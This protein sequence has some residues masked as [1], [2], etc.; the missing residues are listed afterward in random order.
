MPSNAKMS[1]LTRL[2]IRF[3][4]VALAIGM[5]P[6]KAAAQE[7]VPRNPILIISSYNPDSHGI[8]STISAFENKFREL[9][10]QVAV[11]TENM[12]CKSLT[13][14]FDW[15]DNLGVILAKYVE[16]QRPSVIILLGQEAWSAYLSQGERLDTSIPVLC[17]MISSNAVLL[18][19]KG[20][21]ALDEWEPESIEAFTD[22]NRIKQIGGYAYRYD[23]AKNVELILDFFPQTQYVAFISDNTYGGVAMQA[24][25]KKE[26]AR[27]PSLNLILL[28]GRKHTTYSISEHI[29]QLPDNTAILIGTWRTDRNDSYFVNGVYTLMGAGRNIPAFTLA[30]TGM[31]YWAIAGYVPKYYNTGSDLA[32]QAYKLISAGQGEHPLELVQLAN[33]YHFDA[34]KLKEFGFQRKKLPADSIIEHAEPSFWSQYK[35]ELSIVIA[36]FFALVVGLLIS[37][38][39]YIRALSLQ[40]YLEQSEKDLV[41]ARDRAEESNRLKTAFLANM[42]HEIRTPL[43]AIVGFSSVLSSEACSDEEMAEY[44]KI[45]KI[46]S[47]LLLRLINDI[48]D[49][50]RM[51]SGRMKF[52]YEMYDIVP[53][54]SSV[55][56]TC[57]RSGK[58]GVAYVFDSPVESFMLCTDQQRLQQVLINLVGNAGKFTDQ[59]SITLKFEIDKPN[60]QL[61]FS[62]TD[63][64]CGIPPEKQKLVFERFEKLD[65]MVQGTGLGLSICR[66]TVDKFGGDIWVDPDYTGGARFVFTHPLTRPETDSENE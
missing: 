1:R 34:V 14:A 52:N 27:F 16:D 63:T 43:N 22:D 60:D 56:A 49:I 46:N 20:E 29:S 12:N 50:S 62:V 25:V 39:M 32:Q 58:E 15:T 59:G 45:I 37:L 26:M 18:P 13:E 23:V 64:G 4:C 7:Y 36:T 53:L 31:G 51:E 2:I 30:S 28:D 10:G 19:K 44:S 57:E 9:G 42:S 6:L 17:G 38:M 40:R 11:I 41:I 3:L 5:P 21:V 35:Y 55:I 24:L 54:C 33:E 61:V 48:L 65:D 8:S 47:D 66:L